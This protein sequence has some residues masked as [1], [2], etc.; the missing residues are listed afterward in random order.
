MMRRAV[1]PG[2]FDPPTSGH[3]DIIRRAAELFDEVW[4]TVFDHP[5]KSGLLS[6]AERVALLQQVVAEWPGVRVDRSRSLLVDYCHRVGARFVVRGLRGAADLDYEWPMTQ[7][8]RRLAPD[9]DTVFLLAAPQ[10][11]YVSSSLVR[12]L[13]GYG[14]PLTGL[15]PPLVEE[16]L[17]KLR[18]GTPPDGQNGSVGIGTG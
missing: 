12:E 15:V 5:T 14:A 11:A 7:M 2:S 3:M 1:Y 16:A 6:P 13:A 9:I 10:S 8:N 17:N 4:V 18:E